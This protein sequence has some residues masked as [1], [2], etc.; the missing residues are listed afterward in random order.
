MTSD[1]TAHTA[2]HAPD[3]ERLESVLAPRPDPGPQHRHH[4]DDPGRHRRR[5]R[6]GRGAPALAERGVSPMPTI[7][8]SAAF[9]AVRR[10]GRELTHPTSKD[11]PR[12]ADCSSRTGASM[13]T[14]KTISRLRTAIASLATSRTSP[15]SASRAC[16]FPACRFTVPERALSLEHAARLLSQG[17]NGLSMIFLAMLSPI[18]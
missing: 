18:L 9:G 4:R 16:R 6:P 7:V 1:Q 13:R 14:V 10:P 8:V 3:G 12:G 17:D 11:R 2:R 15:S 5:K